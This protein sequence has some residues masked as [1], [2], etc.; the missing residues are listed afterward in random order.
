VIFRMVAEIRP[1]ERRAFTANYSSWASTSRR[2]MSR[3]GFGE[4]RETQSPG[5]DG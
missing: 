4:P 1:R 3:D 2:G 5:N